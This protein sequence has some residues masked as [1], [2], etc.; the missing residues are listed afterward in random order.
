MIAE[1]RKIE[2]FFPVELRDALVLLIEGMSERKQE[3]SLSPAER[4][5][6]PPAVDQA[7]AFVE[8]RMGLSFNRCVLKIYRIGEPHQSGAYN[9]HVDP[10]SYHT[11]PLFHCTLR[12]EAEFF[13]KNRQGEIGR[14]EYRANTAIILDSKLEHYVTAPTSDNGERLYIFF[15]YTSK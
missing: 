2:N 15:G 3:I 1:M 4:A 8:A 6:C 13:Y 11:T 14:V 7:V 9:W 10:E 12:G 5:C